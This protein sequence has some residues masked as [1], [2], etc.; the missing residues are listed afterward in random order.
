M[1]VFV[2]ID[3]GFRKTGL[4]AVR[5]NRLLEA[6]T[7]KGEAADGE[8]V[9]ERDLQA[10]Q[11]LTTGI[12][13][14]LARHPANGIFVE[15]PSG[16]AQG[17][18]ANRCMGLATAL[19]WALLDQAQVPAEMMDPTQAEK[20]AGLYVSRAEMK[21]KKLSKGKLRAWKKQRV[22]EL[23][24]KTFPEFKGW[25]DTK[26][27]FEDACDAAMAYIAGTRRVGGLYARLTG[28]AGGGKDGG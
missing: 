10:L 6:E 7:V 5:D 3:V 4:V 14:F 28:A 27:R 21:T 15:M 1:A 16:G 9:L 23:V 11:S 22:Q 8:F 24:L 26:E 17:A 18:R 19:L 12:R 2:G 13:G 20:L 25:P